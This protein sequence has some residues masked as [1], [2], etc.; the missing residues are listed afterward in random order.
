[1]SLGSTYFTFEFGKNEEEVLRE[2]TASDFLEWFRN[3]DIDEQVEICKEYF[4]KL[5]DEKK[6]SVLQQWQEEAIASENEYINKDGSVNWPLLLEADDWATLEDIE[7]DMKDF[8]EFEDEVR[9]DAYEMWK[10]DSWY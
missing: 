1:M 8:D 5:S 3:K 6:E 4:N 7:V 9:D 10:E 2:V